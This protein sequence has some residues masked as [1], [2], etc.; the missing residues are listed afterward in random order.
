M[1]PPC[2]RKK[3]VRTRREVRRSS[4]RR[5]RRPRLVSGRGRCRSG[6][7]L[8]GSVAQAVEHPVE[9]RRQSV[10]SRPEPPPREAVARLPV[11]CY[12]APCSACRLVAM[13][14]GLGPGYRRFESSHADPLLSDPVRLPPG[15]DRVEAG[16]TSWIVYRQDTLLKGV[17]TRSTRVPGARAPVAQPE[18]PP[19]SKRIA[20]RFDP[21]RG[22]RARIKKKGCQERKTKNV[23]EHRGKQ[24]R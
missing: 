21:C 3:P 22:R 17:T 20:R 18:G 8:P 12:V 9:T 7:G 11:G 1:H 4:R 16:N 23:R 13:A 14:P 10:R 5:Q 24:P 15:C 19:S 2:K 6:G